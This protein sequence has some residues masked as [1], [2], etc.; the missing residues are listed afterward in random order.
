MALPN[1][2]QSDFDIEA[3]M[4]WED[5]QED[6]HEYL[7][8]EVFAMSG[9]T[10]AHYTITL[11]LAATLKKLLSGSPCRPFISGMKLRVD[12]ADAI[13][14]PDIFVT[15]DARDK[16]AEA[17]LAKQHPIFIAEVLS[18]STG[19][20]D[21][22]RKFEFYQKI[23]D[24]QEYLLIEQD[25]LH[26]DLFRK[27]EAGLW[28]LHPAGEGDHIR[29]NSVNIDIPLSTLYADVELTLPAH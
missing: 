8:G 11:N 29:L 23:P 15:C 4:A 12:L 14:Y 28:V 24:L 26:A 9:G 1:I 13:F 3:Y 18:E 10:D 22:G 20:Y 27:N 7:A 16:T 2:K 17:N 21:R 19:A 5:T 25:R 6:R